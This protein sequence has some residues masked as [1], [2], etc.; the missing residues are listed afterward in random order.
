METLLAEKPDL[1]V[2][3]TAPSTPSLETDLVRHPALRGLA[4]RFIPPNLLI[5]GGPFSVQAA[6][7]LA[8]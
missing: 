1:L 3:E 5:C 7:I 8:R 2:T 6:E 4:R